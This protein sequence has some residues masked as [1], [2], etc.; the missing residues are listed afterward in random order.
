MGEVVEAVTPLPG[1]E[2]SITN[3][4]S[5]QTITQVMRETERTIALPSGNYAVVATHDGVSSNREQVELAA[6]EAKTVTLV[7]SLV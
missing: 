5:G 6:N 3:M 4:R 1:A 7:I 2:V